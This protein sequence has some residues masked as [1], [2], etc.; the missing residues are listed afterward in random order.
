MLR[1]RWL[2]ITAIEVLIAVVG[3]FMYGGGVQASGLSI[4]PPS[5]C[6]GLGPYW[7]GARRGNISIQGA[8]AEVQRYDPCVC[9][10]TFAWALMANSSQPSDEVAQVGWLKWVKWSTTTVYYFWEYGQSGVLYN[11]VKVSAVPNPQ[12][13][14]FD[15]FTVYTNGNGHTLFMIDGNG[16]GNEVLNWTPN[17]GQ[18]MGEMHTVDDQTP[19]DTVQTVTFAD[20]QHLYDGTWY[21]QPTH[22]EAYNNSPYGAGSWPS[23]IN[24]F[25]IWATRY[26]S[27]DP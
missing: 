20:V 9:D 16:V 10:E 11:P 6:G 22:S 1:P 21:N 19:G 24:A 15:E 8:Q 27:E 4:D 7:I 17:E 2:G 25:N 23:G 13:A 26:S 14:A 18:W 5:P 12:G 3:L